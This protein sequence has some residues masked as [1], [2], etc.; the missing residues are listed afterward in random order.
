MTSHVL[1]AKST[2][3]KILTFYWSELSEETFSCCLH[4]SWGGKR[5]DTGHI[6]NFSGAL[7][8]I[9]REVGHFQEFAR[10]CHIRTIL[11]TKAEKQ[12]LKFSCLIFTLCVPWVS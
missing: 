9:F 4:K 12:K 3:K 6:T 11:P 8:L 10:G 1:K 7:F 2:P 5:H